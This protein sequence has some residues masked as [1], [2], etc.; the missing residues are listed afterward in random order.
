MSWTQ[1]LIEMLR[2]RD[3]DRQKALSLMAERAEEE[4][5]HALGDC[6][7]FVE[8]AQAIDDG[9]LVGDARSST[10]EEIPIRLPWG[11]EHVHW[12]VQGGTG[13]GKTTWISCLLRDE[14]LAHRSFGVIDC[15]GDLFEAAVQLT[16]AMAQTFDHARKER[17]LK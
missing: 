2:D 11:D 6:D 7:A 12:I 10:G 3:A 13:S 9:L 4:F 17:L 15:K 14:L 16:A 1:W 5:R 8:D